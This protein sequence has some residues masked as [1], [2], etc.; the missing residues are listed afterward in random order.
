MSWSISTCCL[1]STGTPGIGPGLPAAGRFRS[2]GERI[3]FPE[4]GQD[5]RAEFANK[6]NHRRFQATRDSSRRPQGARPCLERLSGSGL[7][8]FRGHRSSGAPGPNEGRGEGHGGP[9]IPLYLRTI[10]DHERFFQRQYLRAPNGHVHGQCGGG[11]LGF[12]PVFEP[13][14]SRDDRR[15]IRPGGRNR[16]RRVFF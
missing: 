9:R 7:P 15:S 6:N 12:A 16:L 13:E 10:R 11:P 3:L 5:P 14:E 2:E 4:R 8:A 1:C